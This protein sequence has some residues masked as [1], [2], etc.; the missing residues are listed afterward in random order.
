MVEQM[1]SERYE[2]NDM[3]E[4]DQN[5]QVV[6]TEEDLYDH[7]GFVNETNSKV[8]S[9]AVANHKD[10]ERYTQNNKSNKK[11]NMMNKVSVSEPPYTELN[12][13]MAEYTERVDELVEKKNA[14]HVREH[15]ESHIKG[16]SFSCGYCDK[17]FSNK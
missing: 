3:G 16:F 5:R 8:A 6:S 4:T 15:V 17:T 10:S 1:V 12:T 2:Q 13:S 7:A 11:Q 9:Y 14:G